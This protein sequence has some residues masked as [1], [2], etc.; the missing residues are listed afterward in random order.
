[1]VKVA[2]TQHPSMVNTCRPGTLTLHEH[3]IVERQ[4]TCSSNGFMTSSVRRYR[5]DR[6]PLDFQ[7]PKYSSNGRKNS[8]VSLRK[9][10]GIRSNEAH[11]PS[12]EW[13]HTRG[14]GGLLLPAAAWR[15]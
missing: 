3:N 6:S 2:K 1:M 5:L 11:Q 10:C 14:N 8:F 12:C 15:C 9:C 7:M 13:S 4:L